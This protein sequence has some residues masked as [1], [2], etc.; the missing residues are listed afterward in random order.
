MLIR[1]LLLLTSSLSIIALPVAAQTPAGAASPARAAVSFAIVK[2]S[3]VRV[4]ED[5]LFAG[6]SASREVDSNFSAFVIRHGDELLLLD[7]GLGSQVAT[8]YSQDMPL[9]SRPFFRYD[10]PVRPARDQ[11]AAAGLPPIRRILLSHGHWDH[12]SGIADFPGAE[13]GLPTQELAFVRSPQGGV[14]G[15]WASQVADKPVRWHALQFQPQPYEGFDSHLDLFGDG[16]VVL[17]PMFGHT[18]GSMGLFLSVSS[19]RR[20]FFVGDVVWSAAA[21]AQGQ[22]KF[23]AARALVDGDTDA[24]AATIAKIRAVITRDPAIVVVPA[25]DGAVQ[26][27]LGYLPKWVE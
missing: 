2:T 25:H 16:R 24:T 9:W 17:V 26:G 11:L 3:Q 1:L 4:R 20:F 7:T 22:P 13:V 27:R 5:L 10:D 15:A 14:G 12:A 6:G 21:L 23:W 19:G 8:Q 18:P